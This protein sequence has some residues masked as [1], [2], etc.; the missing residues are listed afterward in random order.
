MHSQYLLTKIRFLLLLLIVITIFLALLFTVRS[1]QVTSEDLKFSQSIFSHRSNI[2]T[3]ALLFV[4]TLGNQLAIA[5]GMLV[6]ALLILRK[7]WKT[8]LLF[9]GALLI[10]TILFYLLKNLVGRPRPDLI[11][12]LITETSFSFPSG[13]TTTAFTLYPIIAL[14]FGQMTKNRKVQ[15]GIFL[16]AILLA[17]LVGISRVYLGVHYVTDVVG[18]MLIGLGTTI[19]F[20]L[21]NDYIKPNKSLINSTLQLD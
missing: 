16:F 21:A 20:S 15:I 19:L 14:I 1:T 10:S 12:Q 7:K 4:T 6:L 13:H 11:Y 8:I 3:G 5:L 18:G 2:L 17:S 9:G